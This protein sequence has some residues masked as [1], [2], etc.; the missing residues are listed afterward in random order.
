MPMSGGHAT[1]V[2]DASNG[3][4]AFV[5]T[6][7]PLRLRQMTANG[8]GTTPGTELGSSGGYVA[9]TGAPTVAFAAAAVAAGEAKAASSGAVTI[10]NMPA[11]TIVGVEIWDSAGTPVRKWYGALASSKTT[12]AGDTLSYATGAVSNAIGV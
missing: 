4:S 2:V 11:T 5:A 6:T 7:A 9:G 8:S 3:T 10:S 12:A 1:N